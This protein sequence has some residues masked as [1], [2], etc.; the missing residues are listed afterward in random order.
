[1][2]CCNNNYEKKFDE[3]LRMLFINTYKFSNHDIKKFIFLLGKDVQP[4]EYIGDWEKFHEILI[5]EK[6]DFYSHLNMVDTTDADCTHAKRVCTNF[7]IK[8]IGGKS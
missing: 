7:E 5:P 2:F 3:N 1:M 8:K 4:H 6:V